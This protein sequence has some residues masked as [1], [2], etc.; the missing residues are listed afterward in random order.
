M[1]Q[2]ITN[3]DLM[4]EIRLAM[5]YTYPGDS[6]KVPITRNKVAMS[7]DG[8]LLVKITNMLD[9]NIESIGNVKLRFPVLKATKGMQFYVK[10]ISAYHSDVVKWED[11]PVISDQTV[12]ASHVVDQDVNNETNS[13]ENRYYLEL[14]ITALARKWMK[15]GAIYRSIAIFSTD[16]GAEIHLTPE[17]EDLFWETMV[18]EDARQTGIA[19][20]L[21]YSTLDA[22]YAGKLLV[23]NY[24]G[25]PTVAFQGYSTASNKVPISF[26]LYYVSE[27]PKGLSGI[28]KNKTTGGNWYTSFDYGILKTP[29][30]IVIWNPDGS[31]HYYY[32]VGKE[33]AKDN[34]DIETVKE[35][36]YVN[37]YDKS[38]IEDDTDITIFD[39][40]KNRLVLDQNGLIKSLIKADGS[41]IRFNSS[42][43]KI[44][45]ITAEDKRALVYYSGDY[46]SFIEFVE[47]EKRVLISNST[48]GP[49]SLKIQD[50]SYVTSGTS[51]SGMIT[52]KTYKDRYEGKYEYLGN[53]LLKMTDVATNTALIMAYDS[54]NRVSKIYERLGTKDIT[55]L[56][57]SYGEKYSS[58]VK[59]NERIS[60]Y[61]DA[62]GQCIQR[63][64]RLG[65]ATSVNYQKVSHQ[66]T[67]HVPKS[68]SPIIN[69]IRNYIVNHSFEGGIE[70]N[71]AN[72]IGWRCIWRK[73][74]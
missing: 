30:S 56:S 14:D 58:I 35:V 62:Y 74:S 63:I 15:D 47:E 34:F 17:G 31:V 52:T 24:T 7:P 70:K 43:G 41:T 5:C 6:N 32:A 42:N 25:K 20:H 54:Q 1:I 51:S 66:S 65:N 4:N 49:Y 11:K 72:A 28:K 18:I 55:S 71:N 38:Y 46:I 16:H 73:V 22:G 29:I 8:M 69:N 2:R 9:S 19:A 68:T 50:I 27:R 37:F 10:A 12:Y 67:K 33:Y 39:I 57:L 61:F 59:N 53:I 13:Q 3:L 45:S 26:G 44:T 40:Q 21:D 60:N 64:D 23:N 36:V 48:Y